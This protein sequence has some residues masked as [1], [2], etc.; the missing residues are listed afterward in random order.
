MPTSLFTPLHRLASRQDENFCTELLAYLCRY[1]A[2]TPTALIAL[3]RTLSGGRLSITEREVSQ[4]SIGTQETIELGRLDLVITAPT[5]K[6][7]IE[8]KV[9]SLLG[10]RQL[11]RYRDH[12]NRSGYSHSTLVL[13]T[14]YPEVIKNTDETPDYCIRWYEVVDWLDALR[15]GDPVSDFVRNEV[16]EF[17]KRRGLAVDKVQ[18]DLSGG[19]S[20]LNNLML[21]AAEAIHAARLVVKQRAAG[22]GA[23]HGFYL[24]DINR[25]GNYFVGVYF[26]EPDKLYFE[27]YDVPAVARK[28]EEAQ[29]GE[30]VGATKWRHAL[31]LASEQVHFFA[32]DKTS[33]LRCIEKFVADSLEVVR[34]V[35]PPERWPL[36]NSTGNEEL[37]EST[38]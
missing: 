10:D 24:F 18:W 1:L 27:A 21:M 23:H 8:A 25:R 5:H 19:L 32:R 12:L 31:L 6:M 13:L 30:V 34:R 29:V 15:L 2:P 20:S 28:F 16:V 38:A 9:D 22:F 36:E 17:Y 33:Q 14:R 26:N 37:T 7:I 3:L 35:Q 11:A 4:L